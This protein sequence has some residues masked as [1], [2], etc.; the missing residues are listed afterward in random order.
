MSLRYFVKRTEYMQ[1]IGRLLAHRVGQIFEEI[2]FKTWINPDQGNGVDLKVYLG[3]KLV[4]VA[5]ILNWSIK[6][7]LSEKRKSCII[8]NLSQY[9][10]K[11]LVIHTVLDENDVRDFTINGISSIKIGYQL[12]PKAFYKFYLK[13]NKVEARKRD[14]KETKEEIKNKILDYLRE[15]RIP[16]DGLNSVELCSIAFDGES[17]I[18]L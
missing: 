12:L 7:M 1:S 2:G 4:I 15:A 6:S 14:S 10:C 18:T 17:Q 5:E 16:V 11:K 8:R 13:R 9:N 3:D